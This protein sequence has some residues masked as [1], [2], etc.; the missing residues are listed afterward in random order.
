ME[1]SGTELSDITESIDKQ[2]FVNPILL[3]EFFWDMFVADAFL[4][5]LIVIMETGDFYMIPALRKRKSLRSLI[6]AVV[7]SLRQMRM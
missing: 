1:V 3:K 6:A 2:Q 4:E 7:C 5:I